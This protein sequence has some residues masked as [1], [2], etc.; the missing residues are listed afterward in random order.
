MLG[1]TYN[2]NFQ[3]LQNGSSVVILTE[4]I[5]SARTIFL[6]G[7]PHVAAN[8]H[9]L[10]GDSRGHWEGDT[11]VVDSTN[12]TDKTNFRGPP[13]T[14][15]QDIFSSPRAACHRALHARQRRHHCLPLHRR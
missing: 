5:H 10:A 9:Q 7:R 13:A 2:A 4:M 12:F 1:S 15:R 3:I 8:I 11:L 6:D 14:A